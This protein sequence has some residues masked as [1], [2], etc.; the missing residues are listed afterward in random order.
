M[1]IVNKLVMRGSHLPIT[2]VIIQML[3]T[4]VTIVVVPGMRRAIRFG[5]HETCGAG[6]APC[7]PSLP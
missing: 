3:F 4:V 7:R 5:R 6:P 2:I 1:M